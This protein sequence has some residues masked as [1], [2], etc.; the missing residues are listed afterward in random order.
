MAAT[1]SR[2][3]RLK[4]RPAGLPSADNCALATVP[5]PTSGA[6]EGLV[7]NLYMS[8]DPYMRGRMFEQPS[9][10]QPF[11]LGQPLDGGCVGKVVESQGGSFRWGTMSWPQGLAGRLRLGRCRPDQNRSDPAPPQAYL[12]VLGM[13]GL[14]A[15]VGPP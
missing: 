15:Y 2:E 13:P 7:R 3:I 14:M 4:N 12:G 6:G 11:Q 10:V 5:G 1:M 8:V 9:Y